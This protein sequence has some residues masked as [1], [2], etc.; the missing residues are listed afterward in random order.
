MKDFLHIDEETR[1]LSGRT[2]IEDF[3]LPVAEDWDE[4]VVKANKMA[5][6]IDTHLDFEESFQGIE[7]R[8]VRLCPEQ[9]STMM[10]DLSTVTQ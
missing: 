8:P 3:P 10:T 5:E 1:I 9:R 4:L 6:V 2:D 7:M